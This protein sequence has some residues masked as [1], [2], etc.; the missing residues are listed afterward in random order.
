MI[1]FSLAYAL[2]AGMLSLQQVYIIIS[3]YG[4]V[5]GLGFYLLFKATG[6]KDQ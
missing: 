1:C 4:V 6:V 3:I 5:G 2:L